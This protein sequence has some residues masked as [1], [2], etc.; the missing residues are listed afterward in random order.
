MRAL[1]LVSLV[2]LLIPPASAQTL[3]ELC[4]ITI[5]PNKEFSEIVVRADEVYNHSRKAALARQVDA[6]DDGM[7]TAS[8][9]KAF[10]DASRRVPVDFGTNSYGQNVSVLGH[11]KLFV[12]DKTPNRVAIH[13]DISNAVGPTGDVD[14]W[15]VTEVRVYAFQGERLE[16]H[17][18]QGGDASEPHPRAVVEFVVFRAPAGW[19]V[20]RINGTL[21]DR[22]HVAIGGFDT[23]RQYT[24]DYSDE[25]GKE[26]TLP[27]GGG[28]PGADVTTFLVGI[29]VLAFLGRR[30]EAS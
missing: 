19:F 17:R 11:K 14:D 13:T 28:S 1:W 27:A 22:D 4:I 6:D 15:L 30:R 26:Y 16:T 2:L 25:P 23:H 3:D 10:E 12:D 29:V 7:V 5:L 24:V 8:E 9:E 18:I 21:Y 20:H